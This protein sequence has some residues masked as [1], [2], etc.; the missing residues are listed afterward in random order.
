M[1]H[2]KTQ[3]GPRCSFCNKAQ[4][5]VKTLVAGPS[6]FIC[7]ECVDICNDIL[8][9][10]KVLG[11]SGAPGLEVFESRHFGSLVRCRLCQTLFSKDG[12][13]AFPKRGW[14]CNACVTV[15]KEHRPGAEDSA[16]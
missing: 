16:K 5:D 2:P 6:V 9:E 4:L 7:D 10:S 14:L 13:V 12:C 1:A 8:G 15:V 3:D 11:M